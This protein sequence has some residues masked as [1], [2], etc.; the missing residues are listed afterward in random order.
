MGRKPQTARKGTGG[1]YKEPPAYLAASGL[2]Q[3]ART[4][5]QLGRITKDEVFIASEIIEKA[6]EFKRP[7][8]TP[9]QDHDGELGF[10]IQ[11]LDADQYSHYPDAR[12]CSVFSAAREVAESSADAEYALWVSA[13]LQAAPHLMQQQCFEHHSHS[14]LPSCRS[15]T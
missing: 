10:L 6:R 7:R 4:V 12:I 15:E 8:F 13:C 1:Q 9:Y 3:A 11:Q 5:Q 2:R 14:S